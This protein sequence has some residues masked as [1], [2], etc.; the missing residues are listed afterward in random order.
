MTL[1]E[2]IKFYR[3]PIKRLVRTGFTPDDCRFVDLYDDYLRLSNGGG[4]KVW[5]VNVLAQKYGVSERKV[6]YIIRHMEKECMMDAVG[7]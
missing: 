6:Y 3:E 1:F 2:A 7:S 4:K 5:I